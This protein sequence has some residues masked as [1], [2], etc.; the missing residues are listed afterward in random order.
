MNEKLRVHLRDAF[1]N[2]FGVQVYVSDHTFPDR[3]SF[4]SAIEMREGDRN[5]LQRPVMTLDREACQIMLDDL[6]RAGFRPSAHV[7]DEPSSV[8]A[9]LGD[10]RRLVSHLLEV[11]LP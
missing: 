3:P 2:G 4:A 5:E 8:K 10:M 1:P 6:Y 11:E 7:G 9:H